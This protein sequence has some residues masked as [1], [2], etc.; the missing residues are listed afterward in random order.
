M[1]PIVKQNNDSNAA[2]EA[3]TC[4]CAICTTPTKHL[5][6]ANLFGK[7]VRIC[8]ACAEEFHVR[9]IISHRTDMPELHNTATGRSEQ[10]RNLM[11]A[12]IIR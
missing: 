8:E 4:D 6:T 5:I 7:R 10:L 3:A 1:N 12:R 11:R 9:P 2:N